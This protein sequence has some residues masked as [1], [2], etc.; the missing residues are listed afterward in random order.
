MIAIT[1]VI[2]DS[3]AECVWIFIRAIVWAPLTIVHSLEF[4]TYLVRPRH[5]PH[6]Q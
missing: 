4:Y 5:S 2:G 6:V 1:M 3:M